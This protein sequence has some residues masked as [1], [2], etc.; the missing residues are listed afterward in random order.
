MKS[1]YGGVAIVGA[2]NTEQAKRLEREEMDVLLDAVHREPD[3][4]LVPFHPQ[5]AALNLLPGRKGLRK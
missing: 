4:A 1:P 3:P 5:D 2:Y